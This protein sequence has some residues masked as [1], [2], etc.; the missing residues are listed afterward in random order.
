[1]VDL[2]QIDEA[3]VKTWKS[4]TSISMKSIIAVVI[5]LLLMAW[6]FL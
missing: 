3:H 2:N 4:F 5:I 1:M 6:A